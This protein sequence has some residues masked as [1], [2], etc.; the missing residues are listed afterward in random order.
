MSC[1]ILMIEKT[2]EQS[3]ALQSLDLST[4]F[5]NYFPERFFNHIKQK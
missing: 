2:Q 3:E 1:T 4:V 5:V